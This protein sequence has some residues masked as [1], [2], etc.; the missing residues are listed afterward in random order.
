MA[1]GYPF[2]VRAWKVHRIRLAI[3]ESSLDATNG[4]GPPPQK[5]QPRLEIVATPH[6]SDSTFTTRALLSTCAEA[7]KE[8]LSHS[9]P[10]LPD[11]LPL[12]GGGILRCNLTNDIITLESLS[13]AA[14][15]QI[16]NNLLCHSNNPRL[17]LTPLSAIRHL[18][19][20]PTPLLQQ[21]PT[22]TPSFAAPVPIIPPELETALLTFTASFFPG[23]EQ[24]YLLLQPTAAITTT[25]P[26]HAPPPPP[27]SSEHVFYGSGGGE[28]ITGSKKGGE[29]WWYTTRPPASYW[30]TDAYHAHLARLVRFLCRFRQALLDGPAAV[31]V[32]TDR[33]EAAGAGGLLVVG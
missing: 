21:E 4:D 24:V 15:F 32:V 20:D 12:R 28:P 8:A 19:L 26:G 25:P 17:L 33:D 10:T 5:K 9:L 31:V 13:P 18:G 22:T 16:N 27:R 11:T 7:R 29:E 3:A 30:V 1:P 14:L 6:L 2:S 23:L